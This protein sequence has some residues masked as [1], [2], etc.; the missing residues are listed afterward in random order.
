MFGLRRIRA[1]T[2]PKPQT[3]ESRRPPPGRRRPSP[4]L[5]ALRNCGMTLAY[6]KT[7][8]GFDMSPRNPWPDGRAGVTLLGP[9]ASASTDTLNS[10]VRSRRTPRSKR[11][12]APAT[13]TTSRANWD[14]TSNAVSPTT[15]A[16]AQMRSAV[17]TPS[18]VTSRSTS[19]Q[20]GALERENDSRSGDGDKH[21]RQ[22][23][24]GKDGVD[25]HRSMMARLVSDLGAVS[26]HCDRHGR[27]ACSS[28][29][30]TGIA[31]RDTP[32]MGTAVGCGR[33]HRLLRGRGLGAL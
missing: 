1:R 10:R 22:G 13:R 30:A 11:Y 31:N 23:S 4:E 9:P 28:A 19:A 16:V 7:V 6:T 15:E 27:A 33:R 29:P 12:A 24:E 14:E 17:R 8:L 21:R 20:H 26:P 18:P 2:T 32:S 25:A 3:P 5:D